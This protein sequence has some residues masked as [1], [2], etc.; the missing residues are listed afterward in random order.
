MKKIKCFNASL[1]LVFPMLFIVLT[2]EIEIFFSLLLVTK[3]SNLFTLCIIL[4]FVNFLSILHFAFIFI[5]YFYIL[6]L[7]F[8]FLF[9]FFF[10][11]KLNTSEALWAKPLHLRSKQI[12]KLS[13]II[14]SWSQEVPCF[15]KYMEISS[16]FSHYK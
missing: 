11:S 15:I 16:G 8:Y 10:Y 6:F 3:I 14:H 13:I 2:F 7:I 4:F 9:L 1:L 5:F 12:K